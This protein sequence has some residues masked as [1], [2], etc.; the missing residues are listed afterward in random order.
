M[1]SP[2]FYDLSPGTPEKS[3]L[4]FATHQQQQQQQHSSQVSFGSDEITD[5]DSQEVSFDLNNFIGGDFLGDGSSKQQPSLATYRPPTTV[6]AGGFAPPQPPPPGQ[7][8][9]QQPPP[10]YTTLQIKREDSI[11]DRQR[12]HHRHTQLTTGGSVLGYGDYAPTT[13]VVTPTD[14]V[15][16]SLLGGASRSPG[17][18]SSSGGRTKKQSDKSSDEYRKRRERNNIAVRK[19]REKAK[20]RSRN[21]EERVTDLM[22]ENDSLH[23]RLELLTKELNVLRSLFNNVG[24]ATGGIA[25]DDDMA[26][27]LAVAAGHTTAATATAAGASYRMSEL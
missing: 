5:L 16:I 12:Q 1:E 25:L 6:I 14:A 27:S 23:K 19:S 15:Q 13:A 26:K 2:R 24:G 18:S 21:T 20:I 17:R 7:H 3:K 4:N 8:Q 22:N 11:D 9:Q 10:S